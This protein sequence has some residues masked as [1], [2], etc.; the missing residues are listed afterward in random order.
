[1]QGG[2]R[3]DGAAVHYGLGNFAFYARGGEGARTGVFE[4]TVTGRRVDG[5]RWVP[6]RI[7]DQ[8]PEPLT[9]AEAEAEVAAWE[10]QRGCTGLSP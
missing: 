3:L 4:V 1:M 2:G 6:G 7:V 8:R 5:Y 9:G 10:A